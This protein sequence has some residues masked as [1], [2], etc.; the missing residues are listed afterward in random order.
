MKANKSKI[1]DLMC[2]KEMNQ[3]QLA[4]SCGVRTATITE[5]LRGKRNQTITTINKIAAG[6]GC[7]PSEIMEV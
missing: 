1:I 6:L 2:E 3:G 5:I 7:P 4:K